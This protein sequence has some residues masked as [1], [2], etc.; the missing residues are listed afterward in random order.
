MDVEFGAGHI[1]TGD[2]TTTFFKVHGPD[3]FY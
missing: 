2:G 1:R 3:M